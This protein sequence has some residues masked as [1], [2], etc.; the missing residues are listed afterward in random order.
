MN[1]KKTYYRPVTGKFA[2]ERNAKRILFYLQQNPDAK[3]VEI[4]KALNLTPVTVCNH[5]KKLRV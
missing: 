2:G 1:A 5:L 3:G 4:A